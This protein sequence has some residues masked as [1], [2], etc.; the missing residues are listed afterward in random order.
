MTPIS[1][2]TSFCLGAYAIIQGR[3]KSETANSKSDWWVYLGLVEIT[4]TLIYS[5][6][7]IDRL[8]ILDPLRIVITCLIALII[9]QIPWQNFGW[10]ATPWQRTFV[11][12]PALMALV[13]AEDISYLSLLATT[14][15]YLRIA[16]Y[17]KNVRWSY[18]S[19]GFLNWGIIRLAWQ[20]QIEFIWLAAILCLS[21]LYIAQFDPN[22]KLHRQQRHY[23]RLAAS[24]FF[25]VVALFYQDTGII[26]SLVS[27]ALIF[28]GLGFKIRAFLFSGTISLILT[29]FYQLA[30]LVLTYS[31]LKWIVGLIAGVCLIIIAA[32]F[33]RQKNNFTNKLQTY[34]NQ[35]NHWQ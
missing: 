21:I 26:P 2:A 7:I 33:E 3:D 20:Y 16:Y 8:S 23:L 15:F 1:V 5:R 12:I 11:T 27:L 25:C 35:L 13:S 18:L 14:L 24:S 30:I 34:T 32:S 4:A 19:L 9:Y 6:L 28:A 31:F 29:V 10:R 17:Q 22:L